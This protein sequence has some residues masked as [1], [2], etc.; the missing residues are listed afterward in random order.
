MVEEGDATGRGLETVAS[1]ASLVFVGRV[2]KLLLLF[3]T[4]IVMA[5]LLGAAGYGGVILT[6]MLIA[7]STT[8]TTVGMEKGLLRKVVI[9]EAALERSRGVVRAG[10]A[11]A[12]FFGTLAAVLVFFA[13]PLLATR[14]FANPDVATLF[15]IGAVAIPCNSVGAVAIA[16]ARSTRDARPHVLVNQI[17]D[18]VQTFIVVGGLVTLGFG[19]VGA[20]AGIVATNAVRAVA[21]LWLMLRGLPFRVRG[22]HEP[23][24]RPVLAFSAPLML[25]ASMEFV[26]HHTDT[27]LVG[28]FLTS[29]DVGVYNV[30]YQLRELGRFFYYPATFLLP[31]VLTGLSKR[32]EETAARRIYQVTTKWTV[33][34]TTPVFLLLVLFPDVVIELAFGPAFRAGASALRILL[35]SVMAS[36]LFG[37]NTL[38]LIALGHSRINL[39][40]DALAAVTNV[41]L[42]LVLIPRY[43]IVGAAGA[44]VAAFLLRDVVYTTALYRRE[45]LHPFSTATF[46][47][48]V[49]TVVV[50]AAGYAVFVTFFER[51]LPAITAAAVVF[52]VVYV[53]LL[54]ALGGVEPEDERL[55]AEL[56]SRL[57]VEFGRLRS[58]LAR[59]Q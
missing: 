1:G 10:L 38:A 44:A 52:G 57:G 27:F 33:H 48:Y 55:L 20:I 34:L 18:P 8:F 19:P 22:T 35:L 2:T 23:M 24:H 31:P 42:N 17:F 51:S 16:V 29:R 5:R 59:L 41:V 49:G 28:V 11:L 32:G 56:E 14:V 53:P 40:V 58:L 25:A 54:I 50:A 6:T 21:A 30:A 3:A 9:N 4:Q 39:T 37:A 46:R 12:A 36:V 7:L 45:G 13:A 43:G 47:P 15:R 26:I